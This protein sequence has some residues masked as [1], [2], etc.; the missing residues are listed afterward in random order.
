MTRGLLR[1]VN[2]NVFVV[3]DMHIAK[4]R[5]TTSSDSEHILLNLT[6]TVSRVGYPA[7]CVFPK[8]ISQQQLLRLA[9]DRLLVKAYTE[10]AV[11]FAGLDFDGDARS[12]KSHE[13]SRN[14]GLLSCSF[15]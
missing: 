10:A 2:L 1:S 13:A 14:S 8:L 9:F 11:Q 4:R 6:L 3:V 5:R 12:T 15:V 7:P